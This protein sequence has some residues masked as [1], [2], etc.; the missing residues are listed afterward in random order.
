MYGFHHGHV[1][2]NYGDKAKLLF[3]GTDSLVHEIKTNDVFEDFST[4]K[5]KFDIQKIQNSMM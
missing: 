2:N 5:K 4:D 1:K 3:S